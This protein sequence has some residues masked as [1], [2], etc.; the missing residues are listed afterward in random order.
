MQALHTLRTAPHSARDGQL[1]HQV[2]KLLTAKQHIEKL[3]AVHEVGV[4]VQALG[5]VPIVHVPQLRITHD[6][7]ARLSECDFGTCAQGLPR[8][9]NNKG[10]TYSIGS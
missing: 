9:C 6:L 5:P 7:Y 3:P 1:S 2:L 8:E 10:L 4:I